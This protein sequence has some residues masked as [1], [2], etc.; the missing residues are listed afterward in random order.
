MKTI[1]M[2]VVLAAAASGVAV[3]APGQAVREL[4][5]E[6]CVRLG[7]ERNQRLKAAVGEAGAARAAVGQARSALRP[8]VTTR[9]DYTRLSGN[10][11]DVTFM[12][13]G[14]DSTITFQTTQLDRYQAEISV[15]QTLFSGSRLGSDMRAAEHDARGAEL[16]QLQERSDVAFDIRRAF[17]EL[18]EALAAREALS[19]AM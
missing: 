9:A 1:L 12:V 3:P 11:P 18:Y 8:T 13:P 7:L 19:G 2:S 15:Q 4:T 6:E 5:P 10:V 16:R 14:T 17:W